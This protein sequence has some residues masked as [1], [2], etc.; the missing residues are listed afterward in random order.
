MKTD[1][2]QRVNEILRRE[3]ATQLYRLVR[4]VGF[5]PAKVTITR[6]RTAVD[7]RTARVYVSVMGDEAEKKAAL[8]VLKRYRTE[9]QAAIRDNVPIRYTPQ[10]HF[11]LDESIEKG[12]AVLEILSSL[13]ESEDPTGAG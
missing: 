10:L 6:V 2:I 13:E 1:R 8:G 12:S 9:F 5:D 4:E 7:L 3:L 11:T